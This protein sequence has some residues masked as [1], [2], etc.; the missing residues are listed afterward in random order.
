MVFTTIVFSFGDDWLSSLPGKTGKG[1][2]WRPFWQDSQEDIIF[3]VTRTFRVHS[4]NNKQYALSQLL[5]LHGLLRWFVSLRRHHYQSRMRTKIKDQSQ[6]SRQITYECPLWYVQWRIQK[7]IFLCSKSLSLI[8]PFYRLQTKLWKGSVFRPVY[9]SF[10]SHRGDVSQH[11]L[12]QTPTPG[13]ILP[14]G[15]HPLR[16]TP[17]CPVHA[18]IHPL[19]SECRDTPPSRRPLLRTVRILLECILVLSTFSICFFCGCYWT[20]FVI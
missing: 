6:R 16:Q 10:C 18:G 14:P 13:Q 8:I 4:E 19:P 1:S 11:T 3:M 17:P 12:G 9:Q 7:N 20:M 15:R 2:L 5:F